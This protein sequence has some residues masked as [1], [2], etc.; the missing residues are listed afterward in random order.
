M[1]SSTKLQ[2]IELLRRVPIFWGCSEKELREIAILA[3]ERR[4]APGTVL[5]EEGTPGSRFHVVAEGEATVRLRDEE[6][7]RL[8][9]GA[10]FGEMAL[11]DHG[12]C[13]ATVVADTDMHLL[14]L[15]PESFSDLLDRV[16]S[17][18]R[19]IIRVLVERLRKAEDAPCY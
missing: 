14:V 19:K 4:A 11:L 5:V 18:A 17:V 10:F 15:D 3:E 13:A 16:P 6:L 9:P 12:P 7:A 1:A 8:G 2:R